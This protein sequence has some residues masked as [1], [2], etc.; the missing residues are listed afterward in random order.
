MPSSLEANVSQPL[1]GRRLGL[2]LAQ[3]N[4]TLS[5]CPGYVV[6]RQRGGRLGHGELGCHKCNTEFSVTRS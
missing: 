5:F 2:F 6:P 3:V 1:G 4:A